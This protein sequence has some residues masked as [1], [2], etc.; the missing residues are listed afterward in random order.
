MTSRTVEETVLPRK[1]IRMQIV[2]RTYYHTGK[3]FGQQTPISTT[4]HE[5]DCRV[6]NRKSGKSLRVRVTQFGITEDDAFARLAVSQENEGIVKANYR[7]KGCMIC[8][9]HNLN[10]RS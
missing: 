9:T 4:I 5:D 10:E 2:H 6:L 3:R 7:V 1:G 8:A